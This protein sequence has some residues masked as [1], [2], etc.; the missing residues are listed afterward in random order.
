[1]NNYFTLCKLMSNDRMD[2]YNCCLNTCYQ[3]DF[4][5]SKELKKDLCNSSCKKIFPEN[6]NYKSD[7]GFENNCWNTIW[8]PK[9]LQDKEKIIY[10][11]CIDKC[12]KKRSTDVI[13]CDRFCREVKY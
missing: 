8:N 13:D 7:C 10:D 12:K 3:S 9:C 11:C 1:M 6:E 5:T 4:T 2:Q